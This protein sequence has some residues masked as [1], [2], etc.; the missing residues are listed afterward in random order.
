MSVEQFGELV[1]NGIVFFLNLEARALC[2]PARHGAR[3]GPLHHHAIY[4]RVR[5]RL[6][7]TTKRLLSPAVLRLLL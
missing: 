4:I 5:D 7:P 3:L 2:L 1:Q 6:A